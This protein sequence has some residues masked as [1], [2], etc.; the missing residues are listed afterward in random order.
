MRFDT[1][2]ISVVTVCY[3]A[4]GTIEETILSVL[5]QTYDNIEYIIIDGGSTDGT[6]DIIKKYADHLAYWISEPDKGIYDAMNK[7]IAVA[8]GD[9]INFMNAGDTFALDSTIANTFADADIVRADVIYGNAIEKDSEGKLTHHAALDDVRLLAK[10]PIYRHG[11]SFVK[12]SVH[13]RNL[14]QTDRSKKYGY[15]LD[16][17]NIHTM[18]RMNCSFC[19]KDVDIM[20]FESEGVSNHPLQNL[21]YNYLIT[22]QD[23]HRLKDLI[24]FGGS[25][26]KCA[27]YQI[28]LIRNSHKFL[29]KNL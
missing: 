24:A 15:A 14:F 17:L 26:I 9:Y 5:N 29:K 7:G 20:I 28:P 27:L 13:K 6:V 8:T 11:A 3:N 19:R 10:R 25:Y 1:P 4:A 23:G 22:H 21:K 2:K 16:F 18:F 12:S